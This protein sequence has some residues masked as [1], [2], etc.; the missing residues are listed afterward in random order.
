MPEGT[1]F[2]LCPAPANRNLEAANEDVCPASCSKKDCEQYLDI[3]DLGSSSSSS[4]NE[5]TDQDGGEA[6]GE[7]Q[8][9][10]E[11]VKEALLN[12]GHETIDVEATGGPSKYPFGSL[13]GNL[14]DVM[15]ETLG[16]SNSKYNA[17]SAC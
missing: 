11:E 12:T 6:T 8:S 14:P 2:G 4:L 15:N 16:V 5:A 9:E 13:D 10:D 3:Q 7:E 1:T 17:S